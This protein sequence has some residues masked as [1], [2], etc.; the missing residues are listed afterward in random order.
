MGARRR[1]VTPSVMLLAGAAA[2]AIL[3]VGLRGAQRS[4]AL[5]LERRAADDTEVLAGI[6]PGVALDL[7]RARDEAGDAARSPTS[8]TVGLVPFGP[9]TSSAPEPVLSDAERS[10]P[11]VAALL[12]RARDSGEALLSQ[13]IA[14][15]EGPRIL[16][17]AAAYTADASGRPRTTSERR[18]R[19]AGW[20]VNPIDPVAVLGARLPEGSAGTVS[21]G[22]V[23]W[24]AGGDD[25][26]GLPEQVIDV[27][28]LELTVG[29][30]DPSSVG[31]RATTIALVLVSIALAAAAAL[32]VLATGRRLRELREEARDRA[33]QVQLI[34][35]V[36]PLVQQSLE[37]SDVL[38][39]VAVQLS[40][41]FGLVGVALS[42]GTGQGQLFAM[43]QPPAADAQ[44]VLRPPE[45]VAAGETVSLALQRG[46][47][48][49][50]VLHLVAGRDL[51]AAELQSVRALSEL[52]TAAVVNAALYASQQEALRRFRELDVLKTVFLGTASHELRTPVTAIGGFASL[53]TGNWDRFDETQRRDFVER[54][55]ANARTLNAVVQDL[56][57]FS[58]LDKGT[59]AVTIEEIDLG[60]LVE[61]VVDRLGP[62]FSNHEVQFSS[63][64]APKIA[65][66]V[67][68]LERIVT[69]LLTNAVKFSPEGTTVSL[70]VGPAE[71]GYGAQLVVSDQGPGIPAEERAQIF[72]R[73]FRG[74]SDRIMQTRGVGIGLSVVAEFVARLR[75]DVI[76]DDAPGGGAR[77]TIRLPASSD[78]LLAKEAVHAPTS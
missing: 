34:V 40:D 68:G 49:V 59:L 12:D 23:T 3:L 50:A 55:G 77:F 41:H 65:G 43:G 11:D 38:P 1:L 44:P 33:E 60:D 14:L 27:N 26:S 71:D 57:D 29:A 10:D 51:H 15:R 19:L 47:R 17:V 70:T 5:T 8:Q 30:G 69:N 45:H 28:G 58:L 46:A 72:T 53:L 20:V 7:E 62:M 2:A 18:A 56:L 37:L 63:L 13:P 52:V 67:N 48:S 76:V 78:Q 6:A 24:T 22:H 16:A 31:P 74:S 35:D 64:P 54:I 73:F 32:A 4:R 25:L 36:A 61:S 21:D 9:S 39:A 66:D 42:A 75:G